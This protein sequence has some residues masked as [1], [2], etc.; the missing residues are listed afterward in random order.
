VLDSV[1]DAF[2]EKLLE[3]TRA[4][5]IGPGIDESNFIPPVVSEEQRQNI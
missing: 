4:L 1:Y 2:L 5:K 3:K